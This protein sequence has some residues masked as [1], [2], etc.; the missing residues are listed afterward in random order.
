MSVV[1]VGAGPGGMSLAYQLAR[2]GVQTTLVERHN[3][4]DREFRGERVMPESQ[5]ALKRIGV[6]ELMSDL[7]QQPIRSTEVYRKGRLA[8]RI[9]LADSGVPIFLPQPLMLERLRAAA[10]E[11]P[12]FEFRPGVV[13]K[14]LVERSGRVGGVVVSSGGRQESITADLVVAADGRASALRRLGGLTAG[15][16]RAAASYDV[17][18]CSL[19]L[20]AAPLGADVS[21]MY[22]GR[23]SLV[24]AMPAPDG[25]C[26]LGYLLEKTAYKEVRNRWIDA[27]NGA[28][29]PEMSRRIQQHR[30]S[31]RPNHLVVL[32]FT[33]DRWQRPGLVLMGD[34]AHPMSPVG[35]QGIAMALI[36][37]NQLAMR[38]I[39]A[40]D[41]PTA[42]DRAAIDFQRERETHVR[43]V[44]RIQRRL[45]RMYLQKTVFDRALVNYV[46]P[47]LSR[48]ASKFLASGIYGPSGMRRAA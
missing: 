6:W 20:A 15:M 2:A 33:I 17:I 24:F 47:A 31:M 35:G 14:E 44:Q 36:D 45:A 43:K 41:D 37:A 46:A 23:G 10:A 21:R 18:W 22:P 1:I 16:D 11:F 7:P 38:L 34:A 39:A 28:V 48:V 32:L 12:T 8:Y 5:A 40:G 26:Q 30:D 9:R 29:D 4:F 25:S 27:L 19:P 3:T 13:V 42:M